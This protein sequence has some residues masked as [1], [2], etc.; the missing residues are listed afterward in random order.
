MKPLKL[1]LTGFG[2]YCEKT[3]I[4]FSALGSRG[5]YLITGD[6]GAGKTT[7]FDAISFALYG[8]PS[9][10]NRT[11]AMLRSSFATPT[12]PTEVRLTFSYGQKIYTVTRNPE[13]QRAAK[14]GNALI[15]TAAD[16]ELILPDGTVVT[17][18]KRVTKAIESIIGLDH[19]QFTQIA[20]IA[21]GDFLKV[22]FADTEERQKI[23]R[24]IFR[25]GIYQQ[26]EDR[27]ASD[28]K[29]TR[30]LFDETAAHIARLI[31]NIVCT[32][33]SSAADMQ[34]ARSGMLSFDE[35]IRLIENIIAADEGAHTACMQQAHDVQTV[36]D[37][38]TEHI[39]TAAARRT[40]CH[41]L[42][43]AEEQYAKT[44]ATLD[45]VRTEQD[46]EQEK[47]T[48][49]RAYGEELVILQNELSVYDV[50]EERQQTVEKLER[51]L[52]HTTKQYDACTDALDKARERRA[53]IDSELT[54]LATVDA[55]K[56]KFAAEKE[57]Q[58]AQL[59]TV[60]AVQAAL[61]AYQE[62]T[63]SRAQVQREYIAAS[64]NADV[65]AERYRSA[66][67]A[68]LD[69]Q[70]GILAETLTPAAPCPVCGSTVHPRP[71]QKS[72]RAPTKDELDTMK[73]DADCAQAHAVQ[74]SQEATRLSGAEESR[75]ID[76]SRQLHDLYGDTALDSAAEKIAAH[77]AAL[78]ANSAV[79]N[80]KIVDNETAIA[81]KKQLETQ[82][83][84][85][86]ADI[87]EQEKQQD[88]LHTAITY[89]EVSISE[90]KKYIAELQREI[91][92]PDRAHAVEK[93]T[94]LTET[95]TQIEKRRTDRQLKFDACEKTIIE[96]TGRIDQLKQQLDGM[97]QYDEAQELE[98]KQ[99]VEQH[100]D[101]LIEIQKQLYIR[102]AK[103]TEVLTELKAT[104]QAHQ[105][106][107]SKLQWLTPLAKT[108]AGM[109]GD[110]KDKI[111]LETY[112]QI[113]YF[114]R[115]I[116]RANRRL[117]VMTNGQ[118]E[119]A[120][121][122]KADD[123]R[124]QSGLDLDIIDH[125]TGGRRSVKSLSGGESFEAS[126]SLALGLSDEIQAAAGG[127]QL[128]SLFVDEGFG[129][130]SE[131]PLR[132]AL[133]ALLS[134]TEGNK[135]V[136]IISHVSE[137]NEKIEKQIV[138]TKTRGGGSRATIVV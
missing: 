8:L 128:D 38:T 22:L 84:H 102:T 68:F 26:L 30:R 47:E 104:I 109:I 61:T 6:T 14:R 77:M 37:A 39:I 89:D 78:G 124:S 134:I 2:T 12:I 11:T 51:S 75:Q 113:T 130:L 36:L 48:V 100:K 79:T 10:E 55:E 93:I 16:A 119:F 33:E 81:R 67:K 116:H 101:T 23:F 40:A 73:A 127:V 133:K 44:A 49:Y 34:K 94:Q 132:Q 19:N 35:V 60:Q 123:A 105:Q 117:M 76:L 88:E 118:Y 106:H 20:L 90:C 92:F 122:T 24:K 85:C 72:A 95:R 42:S 135:L 137:L 46:R 99:A 31:D 83:L 9:G 18:T 97:E 13:Y 17:Q 1:E 96:L 56:E 3:V 126:L 54:S 53:Q 103:N 71:A 32:D 25:T 4:D 64:Q 15:K 63:E 74:K 5:L 112:V 43:E 115:I 66:Y 41:R 80:K 29:E 121:K 138:V 59:E 129:T 7:I 120:R 98:K 27:I 57:R 58:T 82:R 111:K 28:T 110:G 125:F 62:I 108:A 65:Y 136:G 50:L 114:E 21:Q 70:A 87:R 86:D 91:H 131:E 107:A 69:E 45:T 52:A